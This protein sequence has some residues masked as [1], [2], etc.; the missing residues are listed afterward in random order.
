MPERTLI[1]IGVVSVAIAVI[2]AVTVYY[3]MSAAKAN[4][5]NVI[6]P[7]SAS[8]QPGNPTVSVINSK[9][10]SQID[11]SSIGGKINIIGAWTEVIDPYGTCTGSSVNSLNLTCGIPN[12]KVSCSQDSDCGTGMSCTGGICLPALCPLSNGSNYDFDNTKCSCGGNYCPTTPG[13]PCSQPSDCDSSGT[14][15]YCDTNSNTCRVNPGQVCMAPDQYQGKFCSL[16]P[17]CSNVDK[18]VTKN[19]SNIICEPGS[20]SKCRPRDSSAYLAA[21]C[22][23]QTTCNITFD[24]TNSDSGFGPS[25]CVPNINSNNLPITPGQGGSYTQGYYVHGIYTCVTK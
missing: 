2:A 1:F 5:N 23:G 9:G 11:C 3:Q 10:T 21:K 16:Y 12:S 20:K 17:L 7:F 15:M 22:D 25:P 8:I 4:Q 13:K 18:N 14:M 24:P 19:V 6:Y